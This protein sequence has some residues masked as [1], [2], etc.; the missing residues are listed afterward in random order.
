MQPLTPEQATFLL[1]TV[2]LP[3]LH[4]EHRITKSVIEAI[5]ADKGDYRP[6]ATS[7]GALDLAWHI[8]ATEMRFLDAVANGQFDLTP[9]PMPQS[10]K[11]SADLA[12]WYSE[13][14]A[15]HLDKVSKTPA[16]QLT[17]IVDFRG[18]FQMPAVMYLGFLLHHTVHHRGQLSVYLR[19][20]G[21]KVPAMYGES[22]DSAEARKAAQKTA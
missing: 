7:R 1:Q 11:T 20:M 12:A 18:M 8:V 19:P 10:I 6:E 17:K 2:Y 13:H 16:E 4:N 14:F 9:R 5:P 15:Q 21:S 22:F 3:G